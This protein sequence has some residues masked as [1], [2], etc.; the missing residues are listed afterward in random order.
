MFSPIEII[1]SVDGKTVLKFTPW[2]DDCAAFRSFN[3]G[4]GVWLIPRKSSYIGKEGYEEKDIEEPLAS[5]DLSRSNWCPG[6]DVWP[7]EVILDKIGAGKH[8]FSIAIPKA[9]PVEGEKMNHWLVSAYLV[10]EE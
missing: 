8:S 6:S 2:R 10:W 9:Q 4:T 1:L 7:E 3:P 5:S